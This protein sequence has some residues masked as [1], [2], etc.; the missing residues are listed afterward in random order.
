MESARA[1]GEFTFVA[2]AMGGVVVLAF[3]N[4]VATGEPALTLLAASGI[5]VLVVGVVGAWLA[6]RG[7]TVGVH[8]P[9][10]ATVGDL[11]LLRIDVHARRS[12]TARVLDPA[13]RWSAITPELREATLGW[14]AP[15]RG[16]CRQVAVELR[17]TWPLGVF[18][19]RRVLLVPLP[20]AMHIAP[21]P[22]AGAVDLGGA[23]IDAS[24]AS[25]AIA[26]SGDAARSVR[27]YVAGDPRRAVHWPTTAR[28]GRLAVRELEP[29]AAT[30]VAIRLR[31][32][33]D[34][35]AN[36]RA[37]GRARALGD[38]A[39]RDGAVVLLCSCEP[40]RQ[41]REIVGS[42]RALARRLARATEGEPPPAPAGW[43]VAEV[44]S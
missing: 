30:G 25:G 16:V 1:P 27:P 3:G 26:P 10:D 44:A 24:A 17:T 37:A 32:V 14:T 22:V 12:C 43:T 5:A 28:T 19:R 13:T 2:L 11:V 39:L 41:V 34:R 7:S 6:L 42:P 8:A 15:R 33:A 35:V 23:P 31:L 29:P 36:D 9:R 21:K 40:G 38:Q 4:G 18:L 20:G